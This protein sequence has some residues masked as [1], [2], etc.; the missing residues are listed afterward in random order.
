MKITLLN[1][2]K[3][4]PYSLSMLQ[5]LVASGIHVDLIGNDDL[6]TAEI[7]ADEKVNYLNLRGD[8]SQ[9]ASMAKKAVRVLKFYVRL[10]IYAATT[11]SPLFHMQTH[12]KF[13]L[14]DRTLLNI[15]YKLL[16]KKLV[17]TAHNIDAQQRDG[18]NSSANRLSLGFSYRLMDHIFVHTDKMKTQLIEE[19]NVDGAKITIIPHGILNTSPSL[20][21]SKS[22]ARN[23]LNLKSR[24]KVLLFFGYI[25]PYKGLEYLIH[26]LEQLRVNDKSFK[27]IIA[28]RIKD[29]PYWAKIE[30][31]IQDL[32]LGK[33]IVKLT[34]HIPDDEVEIFFKSSDVLVLPYKFIFQSGVPFL[35]YSFGL[36]V[37][38]ADVGSLREVVIEGKTG[39][40]CRKEDP[41]DLADKIRRYFDSEL[42]RDLEENMKYIKQYA[43]EEYSWNKIGATI[44]GVYGTLLN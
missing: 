20:G 17:L 36:P 18:G 19:F 11:D 44:H 26:A 40:I 29:C 4:K 28:G 12:N 15:Y 9:A 2:A 7:M 37:I 41:A 27:L 25:A 10:I 34:R 33:H 3:F 22:E 21:L 38:A 6:R 23:R 42:Y 43:N 35:S 24:D 14:F 16:G 5:A 8:Q 39:M 32:G 31:T 1:S 13:K 30:H